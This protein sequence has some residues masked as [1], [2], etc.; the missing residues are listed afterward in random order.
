MPKMKAHSG[1]QKRFRATKN[2]RIKRS[3]AYRRH[4]AWS[5]TQKQIVNLRGVAYVS[6]ADEPRIQR[7]LMA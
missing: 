3:K 2:G 7:L 5:K 1:A 6:E 4:H